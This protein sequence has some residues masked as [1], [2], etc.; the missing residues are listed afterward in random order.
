MNRMKRTIS[1]LLIFSLLATFAS[2]SAR[3]TGHGRRTSDEPFKPEKDDVIVIPE[4]TDPY[5]TPEP[6]DGITD[7]TMF[8]DR[9]GNE[10]EYDNRIRELIAQM[11]GVRVTESYITGI[12][13]EEAVGALI[14]SGNLPDYFYGGSEIHDLYTAGDLVAWDPY[15]DIYPNLREL[16]SEA[17]WARFRQ[18]DGKIYWADVFD[19]HYE[20]DTSTTH[21]GFAFWIQVRVLEWAGY[22]KIETLD[23]YFDLLEA[24]TEANPR[25]PDGT[26]VI[27]Y[28]CLCEDWRYFSIEMAPMFLDGHPY[29]GCVSVDVDPDTKLPVI[30]DYNTTDTAEA[31]F[32][33]LNEEYENGIVDPDFAIQTYDEYISKVMTG[34]VLGMCDMYWDF[35]YMAEDSFS[36]TPVNDPYGRTKTLSELGCDYVPL[37]LVA[38]QGMEQR[39]HT[40]EE[41]TDYSSGIAVTTSCTDPDL[42]FRF[43]NDILE[44]DIH[45][46]RFWGIEGYDYLVDN[47]GLYYRTI[48]MRANWNDYSYR[49]ENTCEYSYMPQWAGMSRD[50][51]NCMM[52]SDQPS[53]FLAGKPEPLINCF[54]AYGVNNYVEMLGSVYNTP[55]PWY[56]MWTWSNTLSTDT[57]HGLSWDYMNECKHEWLPK[58][59]LS[60]D[61]DEDWDS[62]MRGYEACEPQVFIDMAQ[63]EANDRLAGW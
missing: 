24:Y 23:Q 61:F 31:Y 21:T 42:A 50:G 8:I 46:L 10:K 51:I 59:V 1:F 53:E 41:M 63:K 49:A 45:D 15:L 18:A 48:E 32:R 62:Y 2:C 35:G 39:Y 56:P 6:D 58:L 12:S 38:E 22:P 7:L 13:A 17:E 5:V 19:N 25:M 54:K 20:K 34:R 33:K 47:N 43:L 55:D 4:P 16:Y 29:N 52:P 30:S 36:L 40:Y 11:T 3:K 27:P 57:P 9:P 44:Q 60:S 37:G 26:D 28:T 14:A